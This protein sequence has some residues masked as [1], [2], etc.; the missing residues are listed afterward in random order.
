MERMDRW[1]NEFV[2]I[3][4]FSACI[5]GVVTIPFEF[6]EHENVLKSTHIECK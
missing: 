6:K 5:F 3:G 1:K 2:V 4:L